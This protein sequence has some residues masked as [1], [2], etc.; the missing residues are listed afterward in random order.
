MPEPTRRSCWT[1]S[2]SRRAPAGTATVAGFSDIRG[3]RV[4]SVT[5]DGVAE[6]VAGCDDT[7]PGLGFLPDG[8]PIVVLQHKGV[9]VRLAD[10]KATSRLEAAKTFELPVTGRP[11]VVG[12]PAP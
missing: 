12:S 8:T 10:E 6:V 9:V 2:F 3:R 11:E 5:L 7:P 1:G 4:Y